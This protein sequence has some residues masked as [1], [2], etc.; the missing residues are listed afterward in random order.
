MEKQIFI[1]C[2]PMVHSYA[3]VSVINE[4][5]EYKKTNLII[6]NFNKEYTFLRNIE[7]NDDVYIVNFSLPLNV[8]RSLNRRCKVVWITHSESSILEAE[9]KNFKPLGIRDPKQISLLST[10]KYFYNDTP[11]PYSLE[12]IADYEKFEFNNEHS[13][14]FNIGLFNMDSRPYFNKHT[15]W[16]ELL[17]I[18]KTDSAYKGKTLH[19]VSVFES[20]INRGT[21]YV[22]YRNMMNELCCVE[23]P[24]GTMFGGRKVLA[25]NAKTGNSFIFNPVLTKDENKDVEVL[26]TFEYISNVKRWR[27]SVYRA[28]D[29]INVN[30]GEY[31]KQFGGGGRDVVG[32]FVLNEL[33]KEFL[34]NHADTPKKYNNVFKPLYKF[35]ESAPSARYAFLNGMTFG[36]KSKAH[37]E[38]IDGKLCL[39]INTHHTCKE[40]IN[41]F[42]MTGYELLI[43]YVYLNS[44]VWKL[45]IHKVLGNVSLN[46]IKIKHDG[47]FNDESALIIYLNVLNFKDI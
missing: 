18:T 44:G 12:L 19:A 25:I 46:N 11:L 28:N 3:C 2:S 43:Q 35:L 4:F 36:L 20:I 38:V 34:L 30:I 14:A 27:F 37:D 42:D 33:P 26:I 21:E 32:G 23:L 15:L 1:I 24:F 7:D 31:V 47:F 29:T 22:D 17:S 40:I 6:T 10:W 8:M 39:C 41:T 16:S 45:H 9:E 13:E 5:L